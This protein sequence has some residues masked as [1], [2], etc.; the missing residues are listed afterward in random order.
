MQ[1]VA[2]TDPA[3]G[4]G[5]D[6]FTA[7]VAH[8][9]SQGRAVLDVVLERRPPFSP[10]RTVAEF[11]ATLKPYASVVVGD[12]YAGEWPR[13][14]FRKNGIQYEVSALTKS[15]I[16]RDT[17]PLLNS[18]QIELLDHPRLIAQLAGLERRTARG[19]RDTYDHT[20]G[21]HDDVGNAA[22]GALTLCSDLHRSAHIAMGETAG[23][24]GSGPETGE[25]AFEWAGED[26]DPVV[27]AA[28]QIGEFTPAT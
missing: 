27:R 22:A 26:A 4:S 5:G 11:A 7:A 16:Y 24:A 28:K 25:I 3:G 14:A 17:L 9:D 12:R 8:R 18:G 19:G 15:E 23:Y 13:E 20:P 10:E 2:F 21:G 1:Y 6:S